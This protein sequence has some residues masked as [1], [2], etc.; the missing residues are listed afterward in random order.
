MRKSASSQADAIRK[1][2][3]SILLAEAAGDKKLTVRE[4]DKT[5]RFRGQISPGFVGLPENPTSA[6]SR[7]KDALSNAEAGD[8]F[9]LTY[10]IAKYVPVEGGV[11]YTDKII[12]DT[13]SVLFGEY[14]VPD[15]QALSAVEQERVDTL[16]D[17]ST[18][19]A[20]AHRLISL[21]MERIQEIQQERV[22]KLKSVV[23][24]IKSGDT[25]FDPV[26]ELTQII[27]LDASA[28]ESLRSNDRAVRISAI[29]SVQALVY[30]GKAR[31]R[32]NFIK[33]ENELIGAAQLLSFGQEI[34]KI[35]IDQTDRPGTRRM[36]RSGKLL[37]VEK[38]VGKSRELFAKISGTRIERLKDDRGRNITV[39]Q[40]DAAKQEE[41]EKL[42]R[43]RTVDI[44]LG[45]CIST[46][47]FMGPKLQITS[48]EAHRLLEQSGLPLS[49][50]MTIVELLMS[51]IQ[52][53]EKFMGSKGYLAQAEANPMSSYAFLAWG[54]H[55]DPE[56][57]LEIAAGF[58]GGRAAIWSGVAAEGYATTATGRALRAGDRVRNYRDPGV[59]AIIRKITS[60]SRAMDIITSLEE[61]LR[62]LASGEPIKKGERTSWQP[63]D[64]DVRQII[65]LIRP[66][67]APA[68]LMGSAE[69]SPESELGRIKK[70]IVGLI[71]M[72]DSKRTSANIGVAT[73]DKDLIE[74]SKKSATDYDRARGIEKDSASVAAE[75]SRLASGSTSEQHVYQKIL[76][77]ILYG[78][79]LVC[80]GR[81]TGTSLTRDA[82]K[83]G[84]EVK[85]G[86][87]IFAAKIEMPKQ[88][89]I[90]SIEDMAVLGTLVNAPS[91][92]SFAPATKQTGDALET[93]KLSTAGERTVYGRTQTPRA[94]IHTP[95]LRINL[96]NDEI[97][98][99]IEEGNVDKVLRSADSYK[100]GNPLRIPYIEKE[101]RYRDEMKIEDVMGL[102]SFYDSTLALKRVTVQLL[103]AKKVH[104]AS[105]KTKEIR[106]SQIVTIPELGIIPLGT[107]I[108]GNQLVGDDTKRQLVSM[109]GK[110]A[111]D[112]IGKM[113]DASVNGSPSSLEMFDLTDRTVQAGWDPDSLKAQVERVVRNLRND[114]LLLGNSPRAAYMRSL[115]NEM[116]SDL[117]FSHNVEDSKFESRINARIAAHSLDAILLQA[118]KIKSSGA[119]TFPRNIDKIELPN[120]L[121]GRVNPQSEAAL[122]A[123]KR[124]LSEEFGSPDT[125]SLVNRPAFSYIVLAG[126]TGAADI[127]AE[128]KSLSNKREHD[129]ANMRNGQ[130]TPPLLQLHMKAVQ[131][132]NELIE[133]MESIDVM[134]VIEKLQGESRSRHRPRADYAT[135]DESAPVALASAHSDL[136]RKSETLR[137]ALKGRKPIDA[138]LLSD[139]AKKLNRS[140]FAE[141]LPTREVPEDPSSW[142]KA[143]VAGTHLDALLKYA[144][145]ALQQNIS[146]EEGVEAA[147]DFAVSQIAK[148]EMT[149][150]RRAG[151]ENLLR[152]SDF[153]DLVEDIREISSELQSGQMAFARALQ[154]Q[155]IAMRDFIDLMISF[156]EE[157]I[158]RQGRKTPQ[159][160]SSAPQNAKG[161]LNDL[162]AS[163]KNADE[164][165]NIAQ[166]FFFDFEEALARNRAVSRL[167]SMAT[168]SRYD[169]ENV[170]N[171]SLM[172]SDSIAGVVQED[173]SVYKSVVGS[174]LKLVSPSFREKIAHEAVG[175]SAISKP[176]NPVAVETKYNKDQK[177]SLTTEQLFLIRSA[178]GESTAESLSEGLDVYS[179][180]AR[181]LL[182]EDTSGVS[183]SQSIAKLRRGLRDAFF[184]GITDDMMQK[185]KRSGIGY[186]VTKYSYEEVM[187]IRARLISQAADE[188]AMAAK[189]MESARSAESAEAYL[190]KIYDYLAERESTKGMLVSIETSRPAP[191]EPEGPPVVT[192]PRAPRNIPSQ[193]AMFQAKAAADAA[194]RRG[195]RISRKSTGRAEV[196]QGNIASYSS[197]VTQV[198]NMLTKY[199]SVVDSAENRQLE[200]LTLGEAIQ[201]LSD[202]TLKIN[203]Q[204]LSEASA[205]EIQRVLLGAQTALQDLIDSRRERGLEEE[206]E[207]SDYPLDLIPQMITVRLPGGEEQA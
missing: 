40:T 14:T 131:G 81:M 60:N 58:L 47:I 55:I 192:I 6:M 125:T 111:V 89:R 174:F 204:D 12:R 21:G 54:S 72:R 142:D 162:N 26:R 73:K 158:E 123:I 190:T 79:T 145:V 118:K 101:T 119:P 15:R 161:L 181:I 121:K 168:L 164:L 30:S 120:V 165:L 206:G 64:D 52:F 187:S 88:S 135:P 56:H 136:L 147:I 99:A 68:K 5:V 177:K 39:F 172:E 46:P 61:V 98:R 36:T 18:G 149:L 103:G 2:V 170:A 159:S 34:S 137:E 197:A 66:S 129:P 97:M 139:L 75:V 150:G 180:A 33:T 122:N 113:T 16:Q 200:E 7:F 25:D 151:I 90:R 70:I 169:I 105:L 100:L 134:S 128:I 102:E 27:V 152:E 189:A 45:G 183:A 43:S 48:G 155:T 44:L 133:S 86:F 186:S 3:R 96:S 112:I 19:M 127:D 191:I 92:S 198:T 41:N 93:G 193:R 77:N 104:D 22:E 185:M 32:D 199:R 143:S 175:R 195:A 182:S 20:Q 126:R 74:A 153:K 166:S 157:S 49:V 94:E 67:G 173:D 132:A 115:A 179:I 202:G 31:L 138:S 156:T 117:R 154:E 10:G 109:L 188:A 107:V 51:A 91:R 106:A 78:V 114:A 9:Y 130:A 13:K 69:E 59:D 80:T 116:L 176:I 83:S 8:V 65:S 57:T 1:R 148:S 24:R 62:K 171:L 205:Q 84:E 29:N 201:G 4:A 203:G 110:K 140:S 85:R 35:S 11:Q 95:N 163:L 42:L 28:V 124:G 17:A 82:L 178:I 160:A 63:T 50:L 196:E 71:Y 53:G 167:L 141:R 207:A 23:A 108:E 87:P 194:R 37:S 184:P 38:E 146:A 144:R 76:R